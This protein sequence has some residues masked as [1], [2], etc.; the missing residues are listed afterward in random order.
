MDFGKGPR[1]G[2]LNPSQAR[3]VEQSQFLDVVSREEAVARFEGALFPRA[4]RT[5]TLPLL[6]ALGL[7]LAHDVAAPSDAP[8][9]DRSNV[10]G[11]AV[12]AADVAQASE[13]SPALLRLNPEVVRCG[14]P[15]RVTLA[16]GT[17]TAIATGAPLPRGADAVVI[18]RKSVV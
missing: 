15:P 14:A 6:E 17:A 18:D 1:E 3:D 11:F 7:P 8:P 9:F 13:A 2:S 4:L 5:R 12:R 16:P 10:D